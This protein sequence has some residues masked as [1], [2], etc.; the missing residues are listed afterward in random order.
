[1][2]KI[3]PI[4]ERVLGVKI[5]YADGS[6]VRIPVEELEKGWRKAPDDGV[7][8]VS[9]YD[10]EPR[11][12][13]YYAQWFASRDLYAYSPSENSIVETNRPS[14]LPAD[15]IVKIGSEMDKD[16]FRKL[17]NEAMHDHAF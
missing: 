3:A 16:A 15:A 12:G 4:D 7:Q 13:K 10:R 9:I 17:Y 2:K 8:V 1:M 11:D 14:E 6:V 5:F